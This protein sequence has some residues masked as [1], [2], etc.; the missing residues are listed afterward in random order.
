MTRDETILDALA[1][2]DSAD[3]AVPSFHYHGTCEPFEGPPRPSGFDGCFW[4]AEHPTVAQCYIP[5]SGGK[6][7]LAVDSFE[8]GNLVRPSVADRDRDRSPTGLYAAALQL[9]FPAAKE[10][11][12][13]TW[14][15]CRS[16]GCPEGYPRYADIV[17]RLVAMGYP[18]TE[19]RGFSAW[20]KT[21]RIGD[22]EEF[23][24]ADYRM[25]GRLFIVKGVGG[26]KLKDLSDGRESDLTDP[27]HLKLKAFR[28]AEAEG[29]DGVAISDFCQSEVH[30]NLGHQAIGLFAH[31]LQ[32]LRYVDVPVVRWDWSE[33]G[34]WPVATPE[35][36]R[37][38]EEAAERSAAPISNR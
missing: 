8:M 29:Y 9:G 11:E 32:G 21:R 1:E 19:G 31:A 16:W 30:G 25:P 34:R 22:R 38:W 36:E 13:D 33:D 5:D 15:N 10:P 3:E 35:F 20:V 17:R 4:L 18:Y 28:Q 2:F 24:P 27:D 14:G 6:T 23:M 12:Y 7:L 37:L 26:L